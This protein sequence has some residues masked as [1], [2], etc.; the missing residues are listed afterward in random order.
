MKIRQG[1]VSNSSSSSFVVFL[2]ENFIETIDFD[3]IANGDEKFPT[4]NFKKLIEKL[5]EDEGLYMEEMYDF[6]KKKE[7]DYDLRD[8]LD[9]ILEPYVI[10]SMETGPDEGQ[11]MVADRVQIEK[12]LALK[13]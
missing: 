8:I 1:F 3:K 13:K 11:I 10:A 12:I 7:R 2:P 4:K 6:F 9:E 5:I